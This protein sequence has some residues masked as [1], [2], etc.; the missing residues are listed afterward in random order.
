[1]TGARRFGTAV[2][3]NQ[4]RRTPAVW[5]RSC[6]NVIVAPRGSNPGT[7]FSMRSSSVR[8][9]RS[10]RRRIAAA[11]NCFV[12]EPACSSDRGVAAVALSLSVTP[13]ASE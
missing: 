5:L 11:V 10:A 8:A 13:N 1:V 4:S 9:P 3:G 12:T 2:G 6:R 7:N